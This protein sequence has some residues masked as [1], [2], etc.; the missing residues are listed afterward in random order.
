MFIDIDKCVWSFF[1]ILLFLGMNK[2]HLWKWFSDLGPWIYRK[3]E[4]FKIVLIEKTGG[5]LNT[6]K[7]N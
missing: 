3:G 4:I 1:A 2:G 6:G 7:Q 5:N